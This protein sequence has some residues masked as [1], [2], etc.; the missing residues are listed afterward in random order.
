MYVN[1]FITGSI[2][3]FLLAAIWTCVWMDRYYVILWRERQKKIDAERERP[4]KV[5]YEDRYGNRSVAYEVETID[6]RGGEA[7]AP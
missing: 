4:V 7:A 5:I 2:V 3:M 6:M 1:G